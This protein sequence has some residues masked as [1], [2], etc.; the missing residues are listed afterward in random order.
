MMT[1]LGT[2][3]LDFQL[4]IVSSTLIS[5][6]NHDLQPKYFDEMHSLWKSRLHE[7]FLKPNT[8]VSTPLVP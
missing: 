3:L 5:V 7:I 4:E 8:Q 6:G 2:T 1:T